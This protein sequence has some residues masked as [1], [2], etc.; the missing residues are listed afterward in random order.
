MT[1]LS[2]DSETIGAAQL[3]LR[4]ADA[5]IRHRGLIATAITTQLETG[6]PVGLSD[7]KILDIYVL[8]VAAIERSDY[9]DVDPDDPETYEDIVKALDN[10]EDS[11]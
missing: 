7:P 6:I 10:L 3:K 2:T 4:L 11:E 9:D 5:V 1:E 8:L